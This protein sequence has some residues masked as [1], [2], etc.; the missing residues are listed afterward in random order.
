M[1]FVTFHLGGQVALVTGASRGIGHELARARPPEGLD[2]IEL[3][4]RDVDAIR[5]ALD[6][7]RP[8]ILVN[9]AGV[10]TNHDASPPPSGVEMMQLRLGLEAAAVLEQPRIIAGDSL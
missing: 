7:V 6:E 8:T 10:G 2:A 3:D 1:E 5:A 9:N 4:L